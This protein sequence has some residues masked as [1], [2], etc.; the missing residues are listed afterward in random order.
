[1]KSFHTNGLAHRDLKPENL[2]I[3][4]NHNLKLIDFGLSVPLDNEVEHLKRS[5]TRGYQAPE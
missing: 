2:M 1:M 4:Q 5:G 3:D